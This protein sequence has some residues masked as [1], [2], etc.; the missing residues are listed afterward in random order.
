MKVKFLKNVLIFV[1]G[2]G[3]IEFNEFVQMMAFRVREQN[4]D[5]D[6]SDAFHVKIYI[7]LPIV[8]YNCSD[9]KYFAT[10]Y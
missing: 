3:T 1:S 6:L 10:F 2:N 9:N 4:E 8:T 7:L 5:E